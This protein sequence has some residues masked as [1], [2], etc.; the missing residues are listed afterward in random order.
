MGEYRVAENIY[1]DDTEMV[2]QYLNA[3]GTVPVRDIETVLKFIA[4]ERNTVFYLD[5]RLNSSVILQP[6][7][8]Y[9]WLDSGLRDD[10]DRSLFISLMKKD[11]EFRG[12][13]VGTL[14]DLVENIASFQKLSAKATSEKWTK[15]RDKYERLLADRANRKII[16]EQEYLVVA[17]NR[18]AALEPETEMGLKLR[19]LNL[20]FPAEEIL[21]ESLPAEEEEDP[22]LSVPAFTPGQEEIT[23]GL[24]LQYMESMQQT[25]DELM[26]RITAMSR[27]SEEDRREIERW[28]QQAEEYKRA[29]VLTRTYSSES[30]T[31]AP[32]DDSYH[33]KLQNR[34]IAVIGVEV[35]G[36]NVTNGIAED[37]GFRKDDFVYFGYDEIKKQA[38]SVRDSAKYAA[39]ITGACPHKTTGTGAYSSLLGALSAE[40]GSRVID[41]R[42]KSG[43][44][45]VTKS[46]YREALLRVCMELAN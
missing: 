23:V 19:A 46:S 17:S 40:T 6:E 12:H 28:Q 5:T 41:A 26:G 38:A 36:T 7:S 29:L 8:F 43:K 16:A 3:Q 22:S 2:L 14:D 45:K 44:L 20:V 42:Q 15:F 32:E 9:V 10:R 31:D 11:G 39:I 25:I 35:L 21:E 34:K 1:I 24:L 27:N 37:L 18:E 13:I 4:A 33:G 30:V